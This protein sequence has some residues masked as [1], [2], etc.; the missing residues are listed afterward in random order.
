[1]ARARRP[2]VLGGLR[3][4]LKSRDHFRKIGFSVEK[5]LNRKIKSLYGKKNFFSREKYKIK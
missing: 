2:L 1:M 3:R 5:K 4:D